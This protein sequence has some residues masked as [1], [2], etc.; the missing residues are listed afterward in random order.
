[1]I[2]IHTNKDLSKTFKKIERNIKLNKEFEIWLQAPENFGL[3]E[4]TKIKIQDYYKNINL[5]Y[6][7]I[8][9]VN[10][11][12][13]LKFITDINL[14]SEMDIP[15]ASGELNIYKPKSYNTLLKE[16]YYLFAFNQNTKLPNNGHYHIDLCLYNGFKESIKNTKGNV[17]LLGLEYGLYP[18]MCCENESIES[19]TIVENDI[20][21]LD[22]FNENVVYKLDNNKVNIVYQ[23]GKAFLL[24]ND[25]SKYD[26]VYFKLW[27]TA[28]EAL[29]SYRDYIEIGLSY[30]NV[31]LWLEEEILYII[32]VLIF[33]YLN[34]IYKKS[35]QKFLEEDFGDFKELAKATREVLSG[36]TNIIKSLNGL[37]ALINDKTLIRE[38]ISAINNIG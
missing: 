24:E 33:K 6:K 11:F 36:R 1:M 12:N 7:L 21:S 23:Y 29:L 25:I 9:D 38:I 10:I 37:I 28:K 22:F 20:N 13:N 18:Y 34:S 19:I 17:L 31:E 35:E 2:K 14:Q 30:D 8:E 5:P 32:K 4:I 15:V 3:N 26:K 27:K 16:M